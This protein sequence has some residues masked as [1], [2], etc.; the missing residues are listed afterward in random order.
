MVLKK[1]F[2]WML[3]YI[4][5][6]AFGQNLLDTSSWMEGTGEVSGYTQWGGNA[7]N[8]R[9]TGTDPY[10]NESVL[11]KA[12]PPASTGSVSGGFDSDYL[13]IDNTKTYRFTIWVKKTGLLSGNA[14]GKTAFGPKALFLPSTIASEE[15]DGTYNTSPYFFQD[16]LPEI[17]KWYL[18]VGYV[19]SKNHTGTAKLGGV[20]DAAS[21]DEVMEIPKEYRFRSTADVLSLRSYLQGDYVAQNAQFFW[22]PAIYDINDGAMPTVLELLAPSKAAAQEGGPS[23]WSTNTHGVHY[24]DGNVGI[25]TEDPGTDWKLAVNGKIR[26]KEIKV[27]TGW[28]DYVFEKDY[29]LPTLQEVEKHIVEKGHLINIPSADEVEANGIELGEMNKLLLEKI[30]EL[31]LYIIAADKKATELQKVNEDLIRKQRNTNARIQDLEKGLKD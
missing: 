29:P 31:T 27:E 24:N 28:A 20:Y 7:N 6:M 15:L 11:W 2:V 13:S 4:T 25:G 17:D 5:Q 22:N 14:V 1:G 21:G 23:L 19:H 3:F 10:G 26:S 12:V 16:Y 18:L 30:E 8:L 9:E